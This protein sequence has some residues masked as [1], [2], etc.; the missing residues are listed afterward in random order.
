MIIFLYGADS[1]R[2]RQRL[3][4]YR[5]GFKKKYDPSGLNAVRLDGAKLAMEDFGKAVGSAGFLAKKRFITVENLIS[6]NKNKKIQGDII[7]YLD[8]E[9][10]D[11]NV[12]VFFEEH[13]PA[14]RG[15]RPGQT[16]HTLA[17]RLLKE[18]AEEF[19]LLAGEQLNAWIR[20]ETKTRR[21]YIETPAILEL[22]S[23]VGSDLWTM[24]SEIDK[25]IS[26]KAGQ[27]ITADDVRTTVRASFDENI[28]HLTDALAER[29][30]KRSCA[31]LHDQLQLG[32]HPL[33]ILTMLVRQFRILLQV[34]EIIGQE[35]NYYTVAS[36]LKLHP[37]VA[38]KAIRDA[39]KFTPEDL[40]TTYR[41]LLELDIA[42]KSSPH[43]PA[44]MFDLLITRV[45]QVA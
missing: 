32:S 10:A 9:W 39:R 31:L 4:F 2:A 14:R 38:Q 40:K 25:L 42:L 28:F 5:D 19:P 34:R 11:D 44:V 35:P 20:A 3:R 27:P 41:R 45:C 18:R 16:A 30:A 26:L 36:R 7:E 17:D 37:F 29:D 1:Y 6:L 15:R 43:D 33:Y 13:A 24:S 22:A 8:S 23:L 21:G 12:L